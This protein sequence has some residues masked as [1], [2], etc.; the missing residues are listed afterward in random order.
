MKTETAL[1]HA[2]IERTQ[3]DETSEPMFLTS[4]FVY[5]NA[6]EADA[7]FA[8]DIERHQYSRF[9]NPTNSVLEKKLASLEGAEYCIT[10][11]SGMA[12]VFG[13]LAGL[14]KA[15]DRI[16][17][18]RAMFGSCIQ[19]ITKILPK[20]G[21]DFELVDGTDPKAWEA[22]LQ[23]PAKIVFLETPSNP[24]GELIDITAVAALAK[25]AGALTVVDNVIATPLGQKPL[26]LGADVVIYSATKHID[27]QGRVL[28]GAI[29]GTKELLTG[30]I[31]FFTRNTGPAL[32]PFNAWVLS[33]SLETMS[34]RLERQCDNAMK[35]A[36]FLHN[37]PKVKTMHYP[38][39]PAHR[40]AELA[41]KMITL[42][43]TVVSFEVE[44]GKS[45]AFATLNRMK[46]FRVSNN[47]GDARS[48]ATHP[49]TTTH[50]SVSEEN[51]I[52][53]GITEGLIRLSVGLEHIDDLI[54]DL[55]Q[56]IDG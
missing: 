30:D 39:H 12:A 52:A 48:L 43:G 21:V 36:E 20:F 42:G 55:S 33:K 5:P 4:G 17:A 13:V 40:Q 28:G 29:L 51:K 44:G 6:E 24:T 45:S 23:K 14:C 1:I 9:S 7:A 11:A 49:A 8:G 15:G 50:R 46:I 19:I 56:A 27:G 34:V 32:S 10:V 3:F 26:Q 2:G 22:A 37:H 53:I 47:L 16:V 54:A 35:V 41:K 18:G 25:K 31:M 38:L